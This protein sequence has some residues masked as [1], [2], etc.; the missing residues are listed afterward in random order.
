MTRLCYPLDV[1]LG[2]RIVEDDLLVADKALWTGD[3]GNA[4]LVAICDA[5]MRLCLYPGGERILID[6]N[7]PERAARLHLASRL[8]SGDLLESETNDV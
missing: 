7:T 8:L 5:D 4:S 1:P 6:E 2:A 3:E